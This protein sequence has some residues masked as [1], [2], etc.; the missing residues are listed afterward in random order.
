MVYPMHGSCLQL[1]IF[2]VYWIYYEE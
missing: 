1:L 2:K